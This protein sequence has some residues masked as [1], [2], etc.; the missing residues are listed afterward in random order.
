MSHIEW[1]FYDRIFLV[2]L[3]GSF[4]EN[5]D[6]WSFLSTIEAE[7]DF[8]FLDSS[9]CSCSQEF[10]QYLK[11][12]QEKLKKNK[13]KFFWISNSQAGS[14]FQRLDVALQQV[15]VLERGRLT[16][17]LNKIEQKTKL[18][19]MLEQLHKQLLA[20]IER[21]L[22][23]QKNDQSVKEIEVKQAK[24]KLMFRNKKLLEQYKSLNQEAEKLRNILQIEP[25][26][27]SESGSIQQELLNIKQ[28]IF[29]KYA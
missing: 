15:P 18:Q 6:F 11:K 8:L 24:L 21:V 25:S 14:D 3:L 7:I 13:V 16:E 22:Q 10:I 2:K 23:I 26:T 19:L 4:Q 29:D 9:E 28:K 17:L 27:Q 20:E 1:N 12:N 5:A